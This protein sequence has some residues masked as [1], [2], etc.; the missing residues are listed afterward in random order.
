[1]FK[2]HIFHGIFLLLQ[3]RYNRYRLITSITVFLILLFIICSTDKTVPQP[4]NCSLKSW[5]K[6]TIYLLMNYI[7]W[8]QKCTSVLYIGAKWLKYQFVCCYG[9][10]WITGN[11]FL[12]ISLTYIP[13]LSALAFLALQY[14]H[15][16]KYQYSLKKSPLKGSDTI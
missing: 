6:Q 1:M 10:K 2:C 8:W 9:D 3:H 4:I 12:A 14:Y 13:V 16:M 5:C 11:W 7:F 15:G